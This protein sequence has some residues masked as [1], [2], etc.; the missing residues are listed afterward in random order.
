MKRIALVTF[1]LMIGC[2]GAE[3]RQT[4]DG[5]GNADHGKRLVTQYGCVT[6]HVIPG[7]EG[8]RGMVGPSLEHMASRTMIANKFPNDAQTMSRWLQNPQSLDPQSSMPN[9][10]VTAADGRDMTAYLATLK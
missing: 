1:I 8:P 7:V 10:G 9:I 4:S 3:K 2:G 5:G 6:C